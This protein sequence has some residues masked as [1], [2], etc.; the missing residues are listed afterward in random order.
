MKATDIDNGAELSFSAT[1]TSA[2]GTI[3]MDAEGNWT[4]LVDPANSTVQALNVGDTLIDTIDY[5][6][7]DE[8]GATSTSTIR[9]TILGTNDAP[10]AQAESATIE[11]DT[12]RVIGELDATDIDTG[13]VL[14]FT[15][16]S[17]QLGDQGLG[18]FTVNS[19]GVWLFDLDN[20]HPT[21]QALGVDESIVETFAYTVTDEHGATSQ[22]VISVTITGTNDAPSQ[23]T[24]AQ[25][26]V[27]MAPPSPFRFCSMTPTPT[28]I[29]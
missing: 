28:A 17:D 18:N 23:L 27:K 20:S 6:V 21:V 26:S 5:E 29:P 2:Y 16:V 1:G 10:V 22:Q 4:Y 24:T 11:E 8:H 25:A 13:A 9:V 12:A 14:T 19:D 15:A 3:S 7:S